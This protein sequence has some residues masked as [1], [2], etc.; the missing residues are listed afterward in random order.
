MT[1]D[2]VSRKGLDWARCRH[3]ILSRDPGCCPRDVLVTD[4]RSRQPLATIERDTRCRQCETRFANLTVPAY[5][6]EVKGYPDYQPEQNY[7]RG[8]LYPDHSTQLSQH[9]LKARAPRPG[10]FISNSFDRVR[11]QPKPC[12][13]PFRV[14]KKSGKD[15]HPRSN[16][17]HKSKSMGPGELAKSQTVSALNGHH[18]N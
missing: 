14:I 9:H 5:S 4:A 3:S 2:L 10:H 7:R 13:Y 12:S 16:H 8:D 1:G 18:A 15:Q 11:H 17:R 6:P